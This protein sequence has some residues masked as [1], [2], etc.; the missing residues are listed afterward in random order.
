MERDRKAYTVH[1]Y[2]KQPHRDHSLQHI[3]QGVQAA[4]FGYLQQPIVWQFPKFCTSLKF[5]SLWD[6][7]FGSIAGLKELGLSSNQFH[8]KIPLELMNCT[9]LKN[10][11]ISRNTFG[12]EVQ[13]V[14]GKITSL[15]SL[16][17]QGN[18]YSGGIISSGILQLPNLICLDLGFN[19]FSG[20]LMKLLA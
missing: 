4:V 19:K 18:N 7:S 10:L 6:N 3:S 2:S 14:L 15:K 1:G 16:V 17:L 20:S 9:N 11:E 13:Q 12:G 5:L 8:H